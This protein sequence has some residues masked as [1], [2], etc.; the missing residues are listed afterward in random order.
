MTGP[1]PED[2]WRG[3]IL[4]ADISKY[5]LGLAKLHEG[6]KIGNTELSNGLRC[7]ARALRPYRNCSMIELADAINEKKRNVNEATTLP[8]R[9]DLVLPDELGSIGHQEL[10]RILSDDGYTKQQIAEVG[11]RRFGISRSKLQRLRK[12]EARDSVRA[13]LDHEKSLDVISH[14]AI[15]GGKARS[16]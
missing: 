1:S 16:G 11:A 5:L 13:A 3:Q 8:T 14:E 9:P 15:C 6:S 2:G 4:V 12:S 10:E 7:L